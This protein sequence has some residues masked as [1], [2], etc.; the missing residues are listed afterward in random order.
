MPCLPASDVSRVL[1]GQS[2]K[3]PPFDDSACQ[4]SPVNFVSP[5][6]DFLCAWAWWR[7]QSKRWVPAPA[8]I[9][10]LAPKVPL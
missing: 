4:P 9:G 3:A 2:T 8:Q 1:T 6:P 10:W 7:P 5:S